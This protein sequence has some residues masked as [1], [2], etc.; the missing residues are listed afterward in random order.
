[1]QFKY[2]S[3][4]LYQGILLDQNMINPSKTALAHA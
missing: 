1:M 3:Q 4:N 2:L